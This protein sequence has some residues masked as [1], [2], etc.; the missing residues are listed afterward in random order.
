MLVVLAVGLV[1]ARLSYFPFLVR[2]VL[3]VEL[4]GVSLVLRGVITE[5]GENSTLR[6]FVEF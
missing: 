5:N 4:V 3:A 2:W 6:N 1:L